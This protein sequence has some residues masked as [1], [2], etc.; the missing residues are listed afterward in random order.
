MANI[1]IDVGFTPN[2]GTDTDD[3]TS[4][5]P[6]YQQWGPD[7]SDRAPI[8]FQLRKTAAP[9]VVPQNF[10]QHGG[11]FILNQ[12]DHRI[13][14]FPELPWTLSTAL[15]GHDIELYRRHNDKIDYVDLIGTCLK[16][17]RTNLHSC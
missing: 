8:L 5:H 10:M 9:G 3:V 2:A 7:R 6:A 11:R 15:E 14:D 13:R 12:D 1:L 4:F 17:L 16:I